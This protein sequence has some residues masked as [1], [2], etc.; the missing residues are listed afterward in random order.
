MREHSAA[1]LAALQARRWQDSE[2]HLRAVLRELPDDPA[3]LRLLERLASAR[4]A[5][6]GTGWSCALALEKL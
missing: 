2:R 4:S 3:A 6:V 1:G 5:Q